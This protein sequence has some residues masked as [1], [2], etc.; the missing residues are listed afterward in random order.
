L[1]FLITFALDMEF[2]PWRRVCTF[3]KLTHGDF[4]L[5]E[6]NFG[7]AQVRVALTGV[8]GVRATNVTRAALKQWHPDVCIAAGLAGSLRRE[9]GIG[10]ICVPRDIMDL[11]T[12]RTAVADAGLRKQAEKCGAV[13]IERLLTSSTMVLTAEGKGRLGKMAEAVEME[14]FAV[15]SE[16]AEKGIPAIAIR[17]ISDAADEDLPMNFAELLDEAGNVSRAKAA[18]ALARAPQRL[19]AVMRLARQSKAAAANLAS[20]LDR[21]ISALAARDDLRTREMAEAKNG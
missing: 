21:Y 10:Q 3:A 11:E 2:G 18:G 17:A 4:A 8:G 7:D 12:G 19:A 5:Y 15:A 14:S 16:A 20:F 9:H 1:K 6:T 13:V